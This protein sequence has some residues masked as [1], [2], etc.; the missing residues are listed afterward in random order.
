VWV[1]VPPPLLRET[2]ANERKILVLKRIAPFGRRGL[3]AA[4]AYKMVSSIAQDGIS[5]EVRAKGRPI[6]TTAGK[7]G[8]PRTLEFS[9]VRI[10]ELAY[11]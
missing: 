6:N 11:P 7:V 1:R 8:L 5:S 4:V 10:Q 2:P 3:W 9:E